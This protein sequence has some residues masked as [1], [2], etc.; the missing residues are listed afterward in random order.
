MN[1]LK[2]LHQE[3]KLLLAQMQHNVEQNDALLN[4]I[5]VNINTLT[6][7][8]YYLDTKL[9]NVEQQLINIQRENLILQ[10]KCTV[11]TQTLNMHQRG[12]IRE[13]IDNKKLK[14][15]FLVHNLN[16]WYTLADVV[17]KFQQS[18][19]CKVTLISINKRFPGQ[20][21]FAGEEKV[22]EF[23]NSINIPH[24]RLNMPDS[25][26]ALEI[27]KALDPDVLF[28]QSQWDN[29][30]PPGFSSEYL[31]F[32]KIAFVTYE[33]CNIIQNAQI[34]DIKDNA[35]DAPFH[36][37]CWRIY[38]ANQNVIDAAQKGVLQA[39]QY[40]LSGHP[41][42]DYISNIS[43][44]WPFNENNHTRILWSPHHSITNNWSN[45]GYFHI[46][47]KE[48]LSWFKERPDIDFVFCPHPALMTML[49][50]NN[51]ENDVC[52]LTH[53]DV[54]YFFSE[55]KKLSNVYQYY[56]WDY[57]GIIK[58]VDVVITDGISLLMEPQIIGKPIVFLE[59]PDHQPFNANGEIMVKSW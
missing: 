55:I 7:K 11:I 16:A 56:S 2:R 12:K 37:R 17:A 54:D 46:V 42:V 14:I 21:E 31:S 36:R 1:F 58:A 5:D 50:S 59:R 6:D 8:F 53:N 22:H 24:I 45:F 25:F 48:M 9:K 15:V 41:K 18:K 34:D 47:W 51:L 57:M 27:L 4:L 38:A 49:Y 30:Y 40:R 19:Y 28:R 43:A 3:F 23:L 10:Q 39:Q 26:Q 33:I 32:T 35:T 52:G 20:Q 44:Q 29:D 13:I